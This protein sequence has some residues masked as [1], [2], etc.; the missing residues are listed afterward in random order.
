V[1]NIQEFAMKGTGDYYGTLVVPHA[2]TDEELIPFEETLDNVFGT[3]K[4][5]R[6]PADYQPPVPISAPP[7]D[8]AEPFPYGSELSASDYT[9]E[10]IEYSDPALIPEV[11]GDYQTS[12]SLE[13]EGN[14]PVNGDLGLK[15]GGSLAVTG[16]LEADNLRAWVAT[17]TTFAINTTHIAGN[18]DFQIGGSAQV[19]ITER[20]VVDGDLDID[21]AGDFTLTK[22]SV[23]HV[24]GN[25]YIDVGGT[26][27]GVGQVIVDGNLIIHSKKGFTIE[28]SDD[29]F[30]LGRRATMQVYVDEGVIDLSNSWLNVPYEPY[31]FMVFGGAGVTDVNMIGN[32]NVAGC[33]H[34]PTAHFTMNGTCALFGAVVAN[35]VGM[36]VGNEAIHHDGGL[37]YL[38]SGI[39]PDEGGEGPS[40][41][42]AIHPLR[43]YWTV[44]RGTTSDATVKNGVVSPP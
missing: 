16:N 22:G 42:L 36:I 24:K 17:D 26:F 28:G 35:S 25:A 30:V 3:P 27:T 29:A 31:K 33:L 43:Q 20:F 15:V 9:T 34:A 32:G 2:T 8:G 39:P 38:G 40:I 7:D 11:G 14:T 6:A 13:L 4:V 1:P 12:G 19:G 44:P 21:V 18:A 23:M 37:A 10:W 41:A 5:E